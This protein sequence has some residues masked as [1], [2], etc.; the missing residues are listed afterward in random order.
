[1]KIIVLGGGV[2][3]ERE[4]SIR[5]SAA[6]KEALIQAGYEVIYLD[7]QNGFDVLNDLP[8]DSLVFPILHGEGGED[9]VIQTELEKRSLPYLGTM[10]AESV[11]CFDKGQT[12]EK[13]EQAGIPMAK[14]AIVD[15]NTYA[16]HELAK[17]PHVLKVLRGGSSIGTYIARD[18]AHI[19]QDD[20]DQVFLLS[21][22]AVIEE[23]VEGSEITVP[24]FDNYALPVIEIVPP[25]DQEFDY[26][27]KYNGLT[28]EI[29]P[30]QSVDSKTQEMAQRLAEQVHQ[31]L[32]A[33]HFSR[34]DIMVQDN[35]Y[36]KVLELNTIP[37]M[38]TQSLYPK[39]AA[40]AGMTMP[41]LV[42]K[43][44][45]LVERDYGLGNG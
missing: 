23:L 35:G 2:S 22:E 3:A 18:P 41:D 29:C 6:V 25:K 36:L 31:V 19:N 26:K 43:F 5:S 20:V 10:S 14:G 45:K 33:R 37:G 38:G 28:Q 15:K 8:A 16:T 40:E 1:M 30:P 27:N 13:L 24:I 7:P 17:K 44:V 4:V 34:V 21:A 32:G 11:V 39:S 9:G 12:R 42:Q